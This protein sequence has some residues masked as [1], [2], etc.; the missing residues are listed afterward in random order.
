MTDGRPGD[1]PVAGKRMI[2]GAATGGRG[3]RGAG[4][5]AEEHGGEDRQQ[6]AVRGGR[7]VPA[8]RGHRDDR[9]D[10]AS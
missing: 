5:P 6:V 4:W 3:I 2:G 10:A 8:Q 9:A 7:V 1:R